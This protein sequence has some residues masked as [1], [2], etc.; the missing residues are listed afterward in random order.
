MI[1]I[2]EQKGLQQLPVDSRSS[3]NAPKTMNVGDNAFGRR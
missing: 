3:S 2:A 1:A